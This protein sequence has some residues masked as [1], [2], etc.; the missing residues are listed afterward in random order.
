MHMNRRIV[1]AGFG[2]IALAGI[3]KPSPAFSSIAI[4]DAEI[5]TVS[6]GHLS[7][8]ADFF[9][10]G[11]PEAELSNILA[12]HDMT[13][14]Q[15][16][17]PCNVTL[18]RS[19][20]RTVLFDA[21]SGSA[22]MPTAGDLLDSLDMLDVT[23]EDI[24]DIVFTHCHPDHLWGVLDDFDDPLFSEANYLMGQVEWDYW[25]NP[26]TV[27]TIGDAR[28]TFAVG[29]ARRLEAIEDR[30]SFF[31]DGQEIMPGIKAHASF[32]HT[33][34]HMCFEIRSGNDAVLVGGD[35]IGN[36]HVAFERP[37]WASGAD[38]D[39]ETAAR[40]RVQLLDKLAHEQMALIGFHLPDG[41]IG[42][43]ERKDSSYRFVPET[44]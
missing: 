30:C 32:G 40:T 34:G 11:L 23:P 25:S 24:T 2:G 39:K 4:G 13:S 43:V 7:M 8:P 9:F 14:D 22:F 15:L 44:A 29:A 36:H 17:P 5:L 6:D 12:S 42:R 20:D 21:G 3:I 1:L 31:I 18:L 27:N 10:A 33:P 28:T 16:K 37:D 38:Q 35:A 26:E 19:G 41:G